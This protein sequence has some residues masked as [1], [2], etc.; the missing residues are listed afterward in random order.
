MSQKKQKLKY[1]FAST[2][3]ASTS[4]NRSIWH[5]PAGKNICVLE[6]PPYSPV[7]VLCDFFC[8]TLFTQSE[9][10]LRKNK[11]YE[12]VD[13]IKMAVRMDL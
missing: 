7:L 1:K 13:N 5:F 8:F 11:H 10:V 3:W 12:D 9:G 2:V 4:R 6:H